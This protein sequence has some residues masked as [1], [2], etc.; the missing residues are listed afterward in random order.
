MGKKLGDFISSFSFPSTTYANILLK[1]ALD[2]HLP[3]PTPQLQDELIT[4]ARL[5]VACRHSHPQSRPTMLMVSQMLSFQTASSYR[6]LDDIT[7]E[8]LITI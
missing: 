4:I 1:D 8:Q 5:S 2:Q 6:G 7:L 3:P